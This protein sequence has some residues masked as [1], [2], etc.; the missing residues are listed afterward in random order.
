MR[1]LNLEISSSEIES[2]KIEFSEDLNII[3][4]QDMELF[5]VFKQIPELGIYKLEYDK[6][7]YITKNISCKINFS[8]DTPVNKN[9]LNSASGIPTDADLE[10]SI[11]HLKI[12]EISDSLKSRKICN[13]A[14]FMTSSYYYPV[15]IHKDEDP[16]FLNKRLKTLLINN[17]IHNIG[18]PYFE[19]REIL[20][21]NQEKVL[22]DINRE[23]QLL[24][25]KKMKK[26]KLQKEIHLT[27]R[28][29]HKLEKRKESINKY[30]MSLDEINMQ[31]DNRNKL[32]SKINNLK[33]DLI[34][35]REIKEKITSVEKVLKE[36]FSHFSGKGNDQI[37]DLE[38]IQESFNAF[39]DINEK[40]DKYNLKKKNYKGWII[41]IIVSMIIFSFTAFLFLLFTSTASYTLGMTAGVAAAIAGLTSL[42]YYF[43]FRNIQPAE[44]LEQKK[45]M[46]NDLID[47]FKKNSF[48]VDDYK[49]GELYEILFQYFEDFINYR[50]ITYELMDLKKK[51]A[52]ST[53]LIEKEKKLGQ[54]N[55]E[56]E[57]IDNSIRV[58]IENLDLSIH[59]RPELN[60]IS[61]TVHDIDELFDENNAEINEKKSLIE[62]FEAEIEEFD[63]QENSSSSVELKL[64][65][66]LKQIDMCCERIEHIKFL[67]TVFEETTEEWSREKLMKLSRL[68]YEKFLKLTGDSFIKDDIENAINILILENGNLK[69]EHKEIKK[70]ISFS[71]KAAFSEMLSGDY[72]P[73]FFLID[74]FSSDNEFAE[75][76]KK[77]LPEFFNGRQVVLIVPGDAPDI[78]GNLITL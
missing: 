73:P 57:S 62:K 7:D 70:Y 22:T 66:T 64:E 37:P 67:N 55:D 5:N 48:S 54:I 43:K 36:K 11:D 58:A 10:T 56:I 61:R 4:I 18:F 60:S 16:V 59:P 9:R 23:K 40:L 71:I 78:K 14:D 46:E 24:E 42:L 30:K 31:I 21:Q 72:I 13:Y 12:D 49:T 20:L 52:N 68:T 27:D 34:E 25:L 75:N 35:L 15:L 63:K 69:N 77:L 19:N 45:K 32:S 17:E 29:V 2:L 51:I 33:K 39:R 41:K 50:D 44:L 28:I 38:Q 8:P 65:E 1:L 3:S 76:M 74:P 47:L 26:V 6:T 53:T